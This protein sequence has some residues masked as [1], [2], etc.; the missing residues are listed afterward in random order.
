ME[1]LTKKRVK[2]FAKT[3]RSKPE[4]VVKE[5]LPGYVGEERRGQ[6]E[7]ALRNARQRNLERA[8]FG[9]VMAANS[10]LPEFEE[11][12]RIYDIHLQHGITPLASVVLARAMGFEFKSA[13]SIID[14][15]RN[16]GYRTS[17]EGVAAKRQ[18][19]SS[20]PVSK[21]VSER[22]RSN[23]RNA[24]TMAQPLM[25]QNMVRLY[26]HVMETPLGEHE[27]RG[28]PYTFYSNFLGVG[29][30]AVNKYVAELREKPEF[31]KA[32][33]K[34]LEHTNKRVK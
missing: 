19:A 31:R 6:L 13:E 9:I 4:G 28:Q 27:G 32:F 8:L 29:N 21:E 18:R 20:E 16:N 34:L 25:Q 24:P 11:R 26:R 1:A 5:F 10:K 17:S 15:W 12:Q 14:N 22:A 2:E 23:A 7:K 33:E 30:A 3:V